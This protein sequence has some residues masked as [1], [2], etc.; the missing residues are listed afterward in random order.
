MARVMPTAKHFSVRVERNKGIRSHLVL[1]LI[2]KKIRPSGPGGHLRSREAVTEL[3]DTLLPDFM[4]WAGLHDL[5]E[6]GLRI[7]VDILRSDSP[8]VHLMAGPKVAAQSPQDWLSPSVAWNPNAPAVFFEKC[9][10]AAREGAETM[11]FG[12]QML[13]AGKARDS[14][15]VWDGNPKSETHFLVLAN[16]VF[17]NMMDRGFTAEHLN[18]FFETA[19]QICEQLGIL[20]QHVRFVSNIGTGFQVGPRVHMH[21]QSDKEGLPSMFPQDYGFKVLEDGTV[22]ALQDSKP[23]REAVRLIEL[24]KK[25]TG[26]EADKKEARKIIDQLLLDQLQALQFSPFGDSV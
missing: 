18:K 17:G 11:A 23:H 2:S 8:V 7:A 3:R 25:I 24:R 14:F 5:T 26:F 13:Y 1:E 21:V 4:D 22:E 16:D 9:A 15:G 10:A 20:D 19:F 12:A 6:R